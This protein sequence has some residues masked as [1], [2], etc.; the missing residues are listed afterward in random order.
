M[1]DLK[2]TSTAAPDLDVVAVPQTSKQPNKVALVRTAFEKMKPQFAMVLP[3]HLTPERLL[4]IAINACNQNPDLL[5]CTQESLLG[6]VMKSAQLGLEPDGVLGQ[7]YLIPFR[8]RKTNVMEVTFIPG[9]KGLIDLAR[10]SGEV[11]NII[12]KEVYANDHF[13]V[14]FSMDV[15]FV[16]RPLLV[17]DRGAITHFWAFA[18]FKDGGFH[19]DYMSVAEVEAVRDKGQGRNNPVWRDYFVEMGKKTA[20]RRIA[21]Y[22][23]MSVQKAAH[24][25][26]LID[27]GKSFDIDAFGDIVLDGTAKHIPATDASL[28]TAKGNEGLKAALAKGQKL[29]AETFNETLSETP[30]THE[31]PASESLENGEND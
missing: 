20:I 5:N 11:S 7:A 10:R 23:P 16:H 8:N 14:D 1:T 26:D 18:K 17:G 25:N 13:E 28:P 24:I 6:A 31:T 21:K 27:S 19:W 29:S 12:A 4:R 9:Y 3:K 2:Q 15:P 30:E 22:L